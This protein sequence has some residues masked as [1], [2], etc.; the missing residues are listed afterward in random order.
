MHHFWEMV[1]FIANTILFFVTGQ[2]IAFRLITGEGY[3]YEDFIILFILYIM[4]HIIRGL[5][6]WQM[7][8]AL[9]SV[10]YGC[11]DFLEDHIH[12]ALSKMKLDKHYH[13]ANWTK[14]E[15]LQPNYQALVDEIF[16]A[17]DDDEVQEVLALTGEESEDGDG[18]KTKKQGDI[19]SP[20]VVDMLLAL[21]EAQKEAGERREIEKRLIQVMKSSYW[22]Q[23]ERG[24]IS[25]DAVH[26]LVEAAESAMDDHNLEIQYKVLKKFFSIPRYVQ[27]NAHCKCLWYIW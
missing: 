11:T 10:G 18:Q 22:S 24:L 20:L 12:H 16:G 19:S 25:S 27:K 15:D 6:I 8:P 14:V 3:G 9:E 7:F 21:G 5:S 13:G 1:G 26:V 2:V 23:Y 17:M 4:C